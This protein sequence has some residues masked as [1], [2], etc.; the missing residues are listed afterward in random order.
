MPSVTNEASQSDYISSAFLFQ[1]MCG[2]F[3][4]QGESQENTNFDQVSYFPN[5]AS[6][7]PLQSR[8]TILD[9]FQDLVEQ[10]LVAL[11]KRG[12]HNIPKNNISKYE[13]A[14]LKHLKSKCDIVMCKADK[15]GTVIIINGGLYHKLNMEFLG[16]I[17]TYTP[18]TWDP[19]K[20]FQS[21]M[22][23]LLMYAINTGVFRQN[24]AD[25]LFVSYPLIPLLHSLPKF[26]KGVFLPPLRPIISWVGSVGEFLGIWIGKHLQPLVNALPGFIHDTKSLVATLEGFSWSDNC[27]WLC[28]DVVNLYPS[29]PHKRSLVCL[30]R[31]LDTHSNYSPE[32]KEFIILATEFLLRHNYFQFDG[33]FFLQRCGASMG[34]RFS[35]SLAN[36]YM[37]AWEDVF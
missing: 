19:T 35:Q 24:K 36:I 34:A 1:D 5:N 25:K 8:P 14:A 12:H 27:H 7:Y 11:K 2:L 28:C 32:T 20:I 18:I 29:I 15:G 16:D 9:I 17:N 21:K 30:G 6:F 10:N 33:S 37:A 4:L 23:D 31:F 13:R 22:K 3:S 26:H